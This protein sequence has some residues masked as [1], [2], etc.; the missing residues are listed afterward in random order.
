M[1]MKEAYFNDILPEIGNYVLQSDSPDFRVRDI[2][3][4]LPRYSTEEINEVLGYIAGRGDIRHIEHEDGEWRFLTF[5]ADT[6]KEIDKELENGE[7]APQQSQIPEVRE[8]LK[9]LSAQEYGKLRNNLAEVYQGLK[10]MRG[11][12]TSYFK[13]SDLRERVNNVRASEIGVVLSGLAAAGLI[14]QYRGNNAYDLESVDTDRI[15][16]FKQAVENIESFE[17]FKNLI[18]DEDEQ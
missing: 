13:S 3:E 18:E 2:A 14:N 12:E 6:W 11:E 1:D 7:S 16:A 9:E 4:A 10:E 8:K 5:E 15:T 17:E